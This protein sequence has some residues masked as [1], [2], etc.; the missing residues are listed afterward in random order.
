MEIWNPDIPRLDQVG[1]PGR[2]FGTEANNQTGALCC[3]RD[4]GAAQASLSFPEIPSGRI[5]AM[6]QNQRIICRDAC[7]PSAACDV[8]ANLFKSPRRLEVENLLLRHQLNIALRGAPH[9]LRLRGSDRTLLVWM[10]WLWPSLLGLSRVVQPSLIS[11]RNWRAK[12]S[13][14]QIGGLGPQRQLARPFRSL[15][16]LISRCR[17]DPLPN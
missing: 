4:V 9:R 17:I 12:T 5:C 1:Q 8:F 2:G 16:V 11:K 13:R 14:P 7:I 15:Y 3:W 6:R 10:T